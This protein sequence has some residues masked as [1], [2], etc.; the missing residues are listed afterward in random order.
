MKN[1]SSSP[2]TKENVSSINTIFFSYG[3]DEFAPLVDELEQSFKELG[4][5]VWKDR[6][7][8][9]SGQEWRYKILTGL[10]DTDYLFSFCTSHSMRN[11][12]FCLDELTIAV[13]F[14]GTDIAGLIVDP[15]LLD[16][17]NSFNPLPHPSLGNRQYFIM[18]EWKEKKKLPKKEYQKWYQKKVKD[19][20]TYLLS[21]A[22][23]ERVTELQQIIDVL[24]PQKGSLKQARL[25]HNPSYID[26]I[27]ITQKVN[28]FLNKSDQQILLLTGGPGTGKSSYIANEY[29]TFS[30]NGCALIFCDAD[31]KTYTNP[32]VIIRSIAYQLATVAED[33][34]HFLWETLTQ[35]DLPLPTD[36]VD[37]FNL[38]ITSPLQFHID[39][40]FPRTFLIIIDGL[41]EAEDPSKKENPILTLLRK[42]I[43]SLP[44]T[45]RF[46]ITSRPSRSLRV[47][48]NPQSVIDLDEEG[49]NQSDLIQ[50]LVTQLNTTQFAF[51]VVEIAEKCQGNFLYAH[52][53][54]EGLKKGTILLDEVL[55]LKWNLPTLYWRFFNRT[56]GND[57]ESYEPFYKVLSVL[58]ILEEPI[59][60]NFIKKLLSLDSSSSVPA[61]V[62]R[63]LNTLEP[64]LRISSS[65]V[66][67]FHKSLGDW[68]T[69]D[70]ADIYEVDADSGWKVLG[71]FLF[72]EAKSALKKEQFSQLDWFIHKNLILALKNSKSSKLEKVLSNSAY[73]KF[74]LEKAFLLDQERK[75]LEAYKI[76]QGALNVA[77]FNN[78]FQDVL[79]TVSIL[80]ALAFKLVIL[81]QIDDFVPQGLKA[82]DELATPE[83]YLAASRICQHYGYN[84]FRKGQ[85]DKAVEL[86][87]KGIQWAQK[88]K[89]SIQEVSLI[90]KKAQCLIFNEEKKQA[91]MVLEKALKEIDFEEIK[92]SN[93]VTYCEFYET[94]SRLLIEFGNPQEAFSLLSSISELMDNSHYSLPIASQGM[95]EYSLGLAAYNSQNYEASLKYAQKA[96]SHL[97]ATYGLKNVGLCDNLNLLGHTYTKLGDFSQAERCFRR[98]FEIRNSFYGKNN[99]L[100]AISFRNLLSAITLKASQLTDE[101]ILGLE[102]SFKECCAIHKNICTGDKKIRYMFILND[103]AK[104]L[105]EQKRFLEAQS[106][107]QEAFE[108]AKS[109]DNSLYMIYSLE[110]LA[111]SSRELQ[112]NQEAKDYAQQALELCPKTKRISPKV[113]QTLQQM[114]Q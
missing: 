59:P 67:L 86:Y 20:Q 70:L 34:R 39:G 57:F 104:F 83:A 63:R 75:S 5:K 35:R 55:N 30:G 87:E 101:E 16:E 58:S 94:Y 98:S 99:L 100:T 76:A 106:I 78:S 62:N 43:P 15:S 81:D 73:G 90:S 10:L 111:H 84:C 13:N 69:S 80:C 91:L 24:K 26:R 93:F 97:E 14:Q 107:A 27:W 31:V 51:H 49:K 19:I 38:L 71:K 72:K 36:P 21:S 29:L 32:D 110:K 64:Y 1:S 9:K 65:Q 74:L 114:A 44:N 52:L 45:I 105:M 60:E 6:S 50:Y 37:L 41:D 3:R 4:Y 7:K 61:L 88:A 85:K 77:L 82:A 25:E 23:Q 56:F 108:I 12:G 95:L 103:Y 102:N 42:V 96:L 22:V 54:C 18:T 89:D 48:L 2:E 8:I 47:Q 33:Y 66:T 53:F 46:I 68:L 113:L 92:K 17:K 28:Q 112:L 109:L 11:P 79:D 40:D